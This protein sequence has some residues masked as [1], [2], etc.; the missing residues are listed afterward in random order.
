MQRHNT[1]KCCA[2]CCKDKPL[3]EFPVNHRNK[4]GLHSYCRVCNNE[5]TLVYQK[6]T[7]GKA[8]LKRAL[9]KAT[10]KGYYRY[11]KGAIPIL[12]QGAEKRGVVFELTADVLEQWW[13][14]QP[15]ICYYCGSNTSEYLTLRDFIL[16]YHGNNHEI[17]KFKRFY[18]SPKH[19]SIRWMTIDRVE[20]EKGYITENMVKSCW[21][22][23]SLK[24]D[25]FDGTQM[26]YIS[27]QI[28]SKLKS[29]IEKERGR[30]G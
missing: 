7:K 8:S 11:G 6:T 21:I 1:T 18:R 9:D 10:D 5:K 14:I 19:Q 16:T 26:K 3:N 24:N 2:S 20:N 22:C 12:K 25:F 28:I 15:D 23:N 29:E 4:D 27:P 30:M 17:K 13:H